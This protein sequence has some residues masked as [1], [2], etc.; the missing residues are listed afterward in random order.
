MAMFQHLFGRD[1]LESYRAEIAAAVE[2]QLLFR[3]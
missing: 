3:A 2:E 1:R